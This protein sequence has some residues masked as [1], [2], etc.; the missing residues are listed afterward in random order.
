MK[1]V[2]MSLLVCGTLVQAAHAGEIDAKALELLQGEWI[3]E[4]W[5]GY[6]PHAMVDGSMTRLY[7]YDFKGST[8]VVTG[9]NTTWQLQLPP[10]M[11]SGPFG[12]GYMQG[13]LRG[14]FTENEDNPKLRSQL[15]RDGA[16]IEED[17]ATIVTLNSGTPGVIHF[18]SV[19]SSPKEVDAIWSLDKN[20]LTIVKA[21]YA[22]GKCTKSLDIPTD[23][24]TNTRMVLRRAKQTH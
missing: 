24:A 9:S 20:R 19:H 4:E 3:V 7:E 2:A 5:T 8:L 18:R 13:L 21:A 23:D 15:K 1:K 17:K 12:Q 11:I 16:T 22:G 6:K 10:G 14:L